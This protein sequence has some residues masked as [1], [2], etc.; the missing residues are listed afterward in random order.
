MRIDAKVWM[1]GVLMVVLL[2]AWLMVKLAIIRTTIIMG[3]S[4]FMLGL[5]AFFAA[6]AIVMLAMRSRRARI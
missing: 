6:V 4:M 5:I 3:G 1:V 2:Y